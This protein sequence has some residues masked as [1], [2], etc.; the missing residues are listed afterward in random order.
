MHTAPPMTMRWCLWLTVWLVLCACER[1]Q[2]GSGAEG[3]SELPSAST[4]ATTPTNTQTNGDASVST[5]LDA[6]VV[7]DAGQPIAGAQ[8]EIHPR[9]R[10]VL[11]ST[12]TDVGGHFRAVLTEGKWEITVTKAKKVDTTTTLHIARGQ[13]TAAVTIQMLSTASLVVHTD[14]HGKGCRK[15]EVTVSLE[16]LSTGARADFKGVASFTELPIGEAVVSVRDDADPRHPIFGEEKVSLVSGSAASVTVR[17]AVLNAD[18]TIYGN[19]VEEG[20]APPAR[21]PGSM[22]IVQASCPTFDRRMVVRSSDGSFALLN[23][24]P[25]ACSLTS[26]RL[27]DPPGPA[28]ENGRHSVIKVVAPAC[29]VKVEINDFRRRSR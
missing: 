29:G 11:P 16:H 25:G 12:S 26:L 2:P 28:D 3:H 19:L 8:I 18:A 10:A 4:S 17:T 6:R 27:D 5:A 13:T 23:L 14:C 1:K 24:V 22:L 15:A 20:G 7:D 21:I 9:D